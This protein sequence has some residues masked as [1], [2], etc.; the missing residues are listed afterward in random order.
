[1][2]GYICY[3]QKSKHKEDLTAETCLL[4]TEHFTPTF[5]STTKRGLIYYAEDWAHRARMLCS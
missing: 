5:L 4:D 2:T 1:M 3:M